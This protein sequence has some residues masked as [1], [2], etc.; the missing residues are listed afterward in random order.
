VRV[1]GVDLGGANGDHGRRSEAS[2][3]IVGNGGV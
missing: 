1:C 2:R 3:G